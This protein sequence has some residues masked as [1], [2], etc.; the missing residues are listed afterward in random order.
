[1]GKG[2]GVQRRNRLMRRRIFT[3]CE[4][5]H[6]GFTAKSAVK[7]LLAGKAGILPNLCHRISCGTDGVHGILDPKLCQILQKGHMQVCREKVR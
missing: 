5:S 6:A 7:G 3:V 2:L 4:R 1:M